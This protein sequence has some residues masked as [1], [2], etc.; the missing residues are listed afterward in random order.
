MLASCSLVILTTLQLLRPIYHGW[1]WN[2]TMSDFVNTCLTFSLYQ[3]FTSI[4]RRDTHSSNILDHKLTSHSENI[5]PLTYLD[6]ISDHLLIHGSFHCKHTRSPK[7]KK[8]FTLYKKED[9]ENMNRELNKVWHSLSVHFSLW[10]VETNWPFLKQMHRLITKY[11]PT[12]SVQDCTT[13]PWFNCKLKRL[14]NKKRH[15]RQAKN[16]NDSRTSAKYGTTAKVYD[17]T[18]AQ[19]KC[20]FLKF[21]SASIFL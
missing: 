10:S 13:S 8:M 20:Y 3:D 14:K 9:Y 1:R 16:S 19:T 12:D 6:G 4:T 18:L 11:I 15:F 5:P 17:T 7:A 2:T 21:H